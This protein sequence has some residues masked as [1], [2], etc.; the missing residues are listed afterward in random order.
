MNGQDPG[1]TTRISRLRALVS[2]FAA[3]GLWS[4][5]D[6]G[7][8]ALANFVINILL[9]RW[10]GVAAYGAFAIAFTIF[11]LGTVIFSGFLVEPMLVFGSGKY[12]DRSSAYL[13]GLVRF[14]WTRCWLVSFLGIA[15]ATFFYRGTE[16]F[17]SLWTLAFLTGPLFYLL[18]MRR[19]CYI[20]AAPRWAAEGGGLY[21]IAILACAY[22]LNHNEWLTASTALLAMGIG[23]L[24]AGLW[25]RYRMNREFSG[26][27]T[28]FGV[29]EIFASHWEFGRWAI[30]TNILSWIPGNVY[31][32]TLPVVG[33][34]EASGELRGAYNLVLPVFQIL[35][36]AGPLLLPA[37]VRCRESDEFLGRIRWMIGLFMIPPLLWTLLL[38][39][40]GPEIGAL[41][42]GESLH[43]SRLTMVLLGLS[44]STASIIFVLGAALKA[45]EHP[46]LVFR[47]Y[48]TATVITVV[49]GIPLSLTWGVSGACA[50][51]V[52]ATVANAFVLAMA[53]ASKILSQR[54]NTALS[55]P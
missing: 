41:L 21:L 29:P 18:L 11:I 34:N 54:K 8:F 27:A 13:R 35:V 19:A 22:V 52:V 20:R 48:L 39:I 23:S 7:T 3:R 38:G 40:A 32:L 2:K 9:A 30:V 45:M 6:Q 17:Q 36:A 50:G 5:A 1:V 42:Y 37:F 4:L 16:S 15:A 10:L 51:M 31:M 43:V 14:H 28:P 53:L 55:T 26:E 33:G 44:M 49:A 24:V 47:G 46:K 25:I 12:K